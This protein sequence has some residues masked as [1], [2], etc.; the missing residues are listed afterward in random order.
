MPD[1]VNVNVMQQIFDEIE[2][3]VYFYTNFIH[4][5][6]LSGKDQCHVQLFLDVFKN[7]VESRWCEEEKKIWK[8]WKG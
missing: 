5:T 8:S 6:K 3:W 7:I 4:F 2:S 1:T